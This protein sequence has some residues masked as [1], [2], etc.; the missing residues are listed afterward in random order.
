MIGITDDVKYLG[1]WILPS[2][3]SVDVYLLPH[4]PGDP[5]GLRH[6]G[7][8]WDEPPSPSWPSEDFEYYQR[9]IVPALAAALSAD[10]VPEGG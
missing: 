5:P 10:G 1:S 7:L 3:N 2:G 4:R 8:R 6:V 9:V